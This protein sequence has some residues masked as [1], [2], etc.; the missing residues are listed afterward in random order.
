MS[1]TD[2]LAVIG[3]FTVVFQLLRLAWRCWCGFRQFVLSELWHVD[4]KT[5]GQWAGNVKENRRYDVLQVAFVAKQNVDSA[6]FTGL[7]SILE[8]GVARCEL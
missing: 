3:G 7:R 1:F 2:K 6:R 4:L 5:Y 8:D